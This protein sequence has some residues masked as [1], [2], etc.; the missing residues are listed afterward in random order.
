MIE[1]VIDTELRSARKWRQNP[2]PNPNL[3]LY[4]YPSIP[5]NLGWIRDRSS[6]R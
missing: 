4:L 1:S 5:L 3:N 6:C 2:N